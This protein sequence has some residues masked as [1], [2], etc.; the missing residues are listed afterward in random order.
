MDSDD[1][2][3]CLCGARESGRRSRPDAPKQNGA[4]RPTKK[5]HVLLRPPGFAT[6]KVTQT[7]AV[8]SYEP[9]EI[10]ALASNKPEEVATYIAQSIQSMSR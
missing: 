9:G 5:S 3:L 10:T 8:Q 4:A 1:V 6:P 2:W 7:T